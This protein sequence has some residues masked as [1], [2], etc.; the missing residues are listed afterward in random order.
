MF[1][2]HGAASRDKLAEPVGDAQ[3]VHKVFNKYC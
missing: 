2:P 3:I 1:E